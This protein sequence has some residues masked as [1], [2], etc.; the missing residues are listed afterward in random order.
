MTAVVANVQCNE[1]YIGWSLTINAQYLYF[2]ALDY[3]CTY[4]NSTVMS[5]DSVL[6]EQTLAESYSSYRRD[7]DFSVT[8]GAECTVRGCYYDWFDQGSY[9]LTVPHNCTIGK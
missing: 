3:V 5:N 6:T 1:S 4:H 8:A 2:H 7:F 9:L